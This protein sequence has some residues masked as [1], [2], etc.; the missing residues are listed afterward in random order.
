L[1]RSVLFSNGRFAVALDDKACIRD[2]YFPFVGLENH[3]VGHQF[4]FGVW[5]D[6]R[7]EWI[8]NG[9]EIAMSYLPETLTSRYKIRKQVYGVEL[10]INDAIHNSKDIFLRKIKVSNILDN[11]QEIRIFF[12]QDFHIYGYEAGDTAFFEPTTNAI[13]HYKANATF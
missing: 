7:F 2:V 6:G 5:V 1:P 10:E 8:D 3:A 11:E 4:R 9:W 12:S 13:I